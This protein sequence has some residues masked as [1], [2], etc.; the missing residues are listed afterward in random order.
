MA[1]FLES[2]FLP[3]ASQMRVDHATALLALLLEDPLRS[4]AINLVC[5][6]YSEGDTSCIWSQWEPHI[7]IPPSHP[8]AEANLARDSIL[9][10]LK[11]TY[12]A[13]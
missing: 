5:K 4:A 12:T 11:A 8:L 7:R 3:N 2:P 6:S 10:L 9:A 1:A 13:P